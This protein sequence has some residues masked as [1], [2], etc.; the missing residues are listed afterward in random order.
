[1]SLQ[2]LDYGM[3]WEDDFRAYQ[4]L[5]KKKPVIV[6]GDLNVAHKEIDLKKSE[7]KPEKC[8]IYR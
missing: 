1:M 6:T 8:R 5:E 3:K 2:R 7:D 4:K